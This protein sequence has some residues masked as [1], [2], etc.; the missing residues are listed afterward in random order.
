MITVD[1]AGAGFSFSLE[2]NNVHGKLTHGFAIDRD[3]VTVGRF[4]T[5]LDAGRDPPCAGGTC[6]LDPGGPYQDAMTWKPAWNDEAVSAASFGPASSC[7]SPLPYGATTFNR[8]DDALPMTCVTWFQ[9]NA[10]CAFEGKRLPTETEWEFVASGHG[11]GRVYPFDWAGEPLTCDV[12]TFLG[13]GDGC[14]FPVPVGSAPNGA[15]RDGIRDLAGSVFEWV[16]DAY[17]PFPED[18]TDHAGPPA[19]ADTAEPKVRHGGAY[20]SAADDGR[21]TNDGRENYPGY[22]AYSDAGFRCAKTIE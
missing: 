18:A 19:S 2:G 20:I 6:S 5:W 15:S 17:A 8:D 10:F 4:K 9:A 1:A 16:W 3:E 13:T 12:V 21:L 14:G 11:D 7:T 22:D